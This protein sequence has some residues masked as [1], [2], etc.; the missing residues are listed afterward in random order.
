MN[1]RV[2]AGSVVGLLAPLLVSP[3]VSLADQVASS[4]GSSISSQAVSSKQ[5]STPTSS[6]T[7]QR[8]AISVGEGGTESGNVKLVNAQTGSSTPAWGFNQD[9]ANEFDPLS[10]QNNGAGTDAAG[11]IPFPVYKNQWDLVS[12]LTQKGL[13]QEQISSV[14]AVMMLTERGTYKGAYTPVT[15]APADKQDAI[16]NYQVQAVLDVL[17]GQVD[18]HQADFIKQHFTP[19]QQKLYDVAMAHA[20]VSVANLTT[21][22]LVTPGTTDQLT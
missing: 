11:Q 9:V 15:G 6:S 4:Q 5:V 17:V 16:Y 18:P 13:S 10:V 19:F 12:V 1:K 20:N 22:Y 14:V 3:A 2:I 8:E 21:A 7:R